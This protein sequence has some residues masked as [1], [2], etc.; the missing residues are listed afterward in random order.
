MFK[1]LSSPLPRALQV[2][3]PFVASQPLS[4]W[5]THYTITMNSGSHQKFWPSLDDLASFAFTLIPSSYMDQWVTV[6]TLIKA[7]AINNYCSNLR[8]L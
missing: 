3:T 7:Y 2:S 5:P 4:G 6:F 1:G 8:V